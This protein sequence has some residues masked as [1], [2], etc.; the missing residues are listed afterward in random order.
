M[1]LIAA[2]GLS[3][4]E[5]SAPPNVADIPNNHRSYAFQW[6]AF[7]VSAL[8]IYGLALRGRASLAICNAGSG[9]R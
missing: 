9:A 7:A 1:R 4:L 8:I 3:G 2:E 5:P 6:F